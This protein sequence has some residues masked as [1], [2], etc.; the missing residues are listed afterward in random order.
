MIL[1][2]GPARCTDEGLAARAAGLFDF[3]VPV[4]GICYGEQVM[5]AQLGGK[6]EG[7]PPSRIRPRRGRRRGASA[8]FEGVW[9]KGGSYPVWMSHGDRV[10]QLPP[11]LS[12]HRHLGERAV[13]GDRRRGRRYYGV[14]FHPEVV[15]T[16]DGAKLLANF[17]HKIAGLEG[18]LDDGAP[19]AARRSPRSARRSATAG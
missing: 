2:G 17:V 3:G 7:R 12:R 15:H 18:R 5:A 14:Q 16:P 10:T 6:V 11:R 19:S 4:L 9:E 8:L 13:R 1:S